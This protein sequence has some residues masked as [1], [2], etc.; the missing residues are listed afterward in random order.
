M[1]TTRKEL[2]RLLLRRQGLLGERRLRGMDG[3]VTWVSRQGF[4][5][6]E[7]RTH[8][9]APSH[10]I[11]LFGRV[12]A[13]RI[14]GLETALY[15]RGRLFEHCLHLPGVLPAED[16]VLIY[17]PE[18][19]QA[20]SRPG[21]LGD[22]VLGYL[23]DEGAA[24]LRDLQFFLRGQ[25]KTDRRAIGRAIHD[26]H[27]S[28]AILVDDREIG[29][30]V[31]DLAERVLPDCQRHSLPLHERLHTLAW[32]AL[33]ILAPMTRTS[34][35]QVLNGI[36]SRARL[37]LAAM[38]REKNRVMD[39]LL[40]EGKVIQ[41]RVEDPFETY[42]L[43]ADW[44]PLGAQPGPSAPHVFFLSPLDPVVW[45][46]QRARDFF[47]YDWRQP[48]SRAAALRR[49]FSAHALAILYGDTL[50]GRIEPQMSWSRRRLIVQGIHLADESLYED[51][52]FQSAFSTALSELAAFHDAADVQGNGVLP[53]R[54]LPS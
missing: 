18:R 7:L 36:G 8:A 52:A 15:E 4:L 33:C 41:V 27:S 20:A 11:A 32:R 44:L 28:G 14:G 47:A 24:T 43:P 45:D 25:G 40:A 49:Q 23:E 34:W 48:A 21:S 51:A 50:V 42:L 13:Y 16:Y 19:I 31:Y 37:G 9:L 2:R 5:P 17:D 30:E 39:E 10:D 6:L 3:A 12:Q 54:L 1:L 35:S 22:L 38:K 26:L 29:Q 46:S 53:R